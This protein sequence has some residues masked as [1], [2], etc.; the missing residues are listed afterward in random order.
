MDFNKILDSEYAWKN[1]S[2]KDTE[3]PE[4]KEKIY[5]PVKIRVDDVIDLHGLTIS[6]A[7]TALD[8]FIE[9]AYKNGFRKVLIIHGKGRHSKNGPVLGLWVKK[10][11]ESSKKA[12]KTGQADRQHGG[13]GATWVIM[14]R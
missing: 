3:K 1:F 7:G 14:K 6:E 5:N 13:S 9:N 12:G 11:L 8:L 10:Y 4:E 2:D